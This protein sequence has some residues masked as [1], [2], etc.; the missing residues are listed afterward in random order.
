MYYYQ[1]DT[2]DWIAVFDVGTYAAD[3]FINT[4]YDGANTTKIT[5][6]NVV[7]LI[8]KIIIQAP[9]KVEDAIRKY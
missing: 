1:A 6:V 2:A 7:G 4:N 5:K 9:L 3:Y 8:Q